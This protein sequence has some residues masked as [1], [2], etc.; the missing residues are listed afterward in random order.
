VQ[1]S[2]NLPISSAAQSCGVITST[3]RR[4]KSQV[5]VSLGCLQQLLRVA[6][7]LF[8]LGCRSLC[9]TRLTTMLWEDMGE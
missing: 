1:L 9:M 3:L 6:S 8:V 2:I 5:L 4:V 7:R